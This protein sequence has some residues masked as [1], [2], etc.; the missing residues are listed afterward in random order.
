MWQRRSSGAL[1]GND[2][3]IVHG[4]LSPEEVVCNIE[5]F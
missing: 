4:F 5:E 3:G 2:V 1:D